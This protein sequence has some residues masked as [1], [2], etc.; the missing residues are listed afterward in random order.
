MEI[1]TF[2]NWSK[3]KNRKF[4]SKFFPT[5]VHGN[6]HFLKKNCVRPEIFKNST[7]DMCRSIWFKYEQNLIRKGVGLSEIWL[8]WHEMT[9]LQYHTI[10]VV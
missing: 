1:W 10:W 2:T 7:E 9:L 6:S 3:S 8:I 5:F 4:S